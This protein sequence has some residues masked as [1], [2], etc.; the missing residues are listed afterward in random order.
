MMP[1]GPF[2]HYVLE[3]Q[4]AGVDIRLLLNG[5]E[6]VRGVAADK[7]ATQEKVNGWLL[8][9]MNTV[10]IFAAVPD[11]A[12]AVG[13]VKVKCQLFNG[14]MGRQPEESEAVIRF[15]QEDKTKLPAGAL[16]PVWQGTFEAKPFYGPW[17]WETAMPIVAG[18]ANEVAATNVV[19]EVIVAL[20]AHDTAAVEKLFAV[21][22][23][24]IARA[25]NGSVE[26]SNGQLAG[27]VAG[28]AA[29]PVGVLPVEEYSVV[30]EE[31]RRLLRVERKDGLSLFTVDPKAPG[32]GPKRVYLAHLPMGWTLVR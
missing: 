16:E 5:V 27:W 17:S 18:P 29:K 26:K 23:T 22:T 8:S 14:P 1:P 20:N 2:I 21:Y 9:G 3:T 25:Y 30:V 7:I 28:W 19:R 13:Q 32:A 15:V 12:Q 10:Q 11:P 6:L 4:Y 31:N 24:E